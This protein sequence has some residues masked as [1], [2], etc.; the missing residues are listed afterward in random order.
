MDNSPEQL[1]PLKSL[2]FY[3]NMPHPCG[4]F[5]DRSSIELVLD[6][7]NPPSHE[8]FSI[9][10]QLGFRR[11]GEAVYRPH[12]GTCHECIP[13]RVPVDHFK[14]NR[15][16][17][18]AWNKNADIEVTA[19]PSQFN[20][21]HFELFGRYINTR[22]ND[23]GM[24]GDDPL[25]YESLIKADWCNARLHE[26]RSNGQLLCLTLTDILDDGMSAVYTFYDPDLMDRSLGV[27]S[28]L[29]HIH[30]TRR[31]GGKYVYLGYWIAKSPKM[32]YKTQYQPFEFFDGQ[33]WQKQP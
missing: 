23:G 24:K 20:Q 31:T 9:L 29:W 10:T 14:P 28:I 21:E 17:R 11:S 16:Q 27:Y 33:T 26:F 3:V 4:Y 7:E 30:E 5:P 2:R 18:R 1:N 13:I 6:H 12:C 15:S 32:N 8:V 19:Q 25:Y 22:H